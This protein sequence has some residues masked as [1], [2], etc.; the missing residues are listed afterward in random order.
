MKAEE[1]KRRKNVDWCPNCGK[2]T[3]LVYSGFC[4][5]RCEY[6]YEKAIDRIIGR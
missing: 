2:L 3:E 5:S 4:S 6:L 1:K